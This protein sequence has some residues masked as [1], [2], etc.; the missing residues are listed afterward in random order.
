M[1]LSAPVCFGE[2]LWDVLPR[3]R[4]LGGAPLNLAYHLRRL[5]RAPRL[6][7]AVGADSLGAETLAALDRAGIN[8]SLV[9]QTPDLATGTVTVT[10]DAA[11][12]A[13]Y[14][15]EQPVAWDAITATPAPGEA[16]PA[17]LVHGSLA[18]R[19]PA[20]RASLRAWIATRPAFRLC[21]LNLRAPYD[22]LAALEEFFHGVDLLKVNADE[23]LR[24]VP[25]ALANDAPARQAEHI[26][27]H[28]NCRLVCITLGA[29]GSLLRHPRG[30]VHVPAPRV[31]VRDTIGA[32]D[33]FTAALL[34]G[35][36]AA[37]GAEPD[38]PALLTRACALGA[39]VASHDGAQPDY[40]PADVPGL[41]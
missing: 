1:S 38:W 27:I 18:L 12:Q 40:I 28:H 20:N 4:F 35:L 31:A 41:R 19:S 15:I 30:V 32:G 23:S 39:F 11:G 3:G 13:A 33:A 6:V 36:L 17:V 2:V 26:A 8:A 21:D 10:L 29:D 5:G 22:D 7:S 34:D 16:P 14:R 37:E 25:P 9:T 24:L